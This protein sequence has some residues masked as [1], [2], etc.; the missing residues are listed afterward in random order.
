MTQGGREGGRADRTDHHIPATP[1][2]RLGR[3]EKLEGGG[4]RKTCYLNEGRGLGLGTTNK[5]DIEKGF[6]L[7][8]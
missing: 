3:E 4:G 8:T 2:W 1:P 7:V 5:E 6:P